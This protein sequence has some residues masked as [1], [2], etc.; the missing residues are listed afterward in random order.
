T[1]MT[2]ATRIS[3]GRVPVAAEPNRDAL[4]NEA[5]CWRRRKQ[6][7]ANSSTLTNPAA[8]ES[9]RTFVAVIQTAGVIVRHTAIH[10]AS[11][12]V[13]CNLMMRNHAVTKSAPP[14][15]D[16]R[17]NDVSGLVAK[18]FVAIHPKKMKSG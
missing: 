4:S 2:T 10:Q 12:S 18:N 6:S 3:C 9:V 15:L 7:P 16:T 13:N 5:Q 14:R 8:S 1:R 11:R 17:Y